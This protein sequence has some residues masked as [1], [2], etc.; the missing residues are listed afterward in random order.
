MKLLTVKKSI[1]LV[2]ISNK[3]ILTNNFNLNF[4]RNA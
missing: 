1:K 2:K 3:I 4:I